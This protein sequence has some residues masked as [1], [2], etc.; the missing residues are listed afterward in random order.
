MSRRTAGGLLLHLADWLLRRTN[1][2]NS[3]WRRP[4]IA[5]SPQHVPYPFHGLATSAAGRLHD[6][7]HLIPAI[8]FRNI[9]RAFLRVSSMDMRDMKRIKRIRNNEN[10]RPFNTGDDPSTNLCSGQCDHSTCAYC[11]PLRLTPFDCGVDRS[12]W[13]PRAQT[14]LSPAPVISSSIEPE[15]KAPDPYLVMPD[16]QWYHHHPFPT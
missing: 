16:H 10:S 13:I 4:S 8:C 11:F 15:T 2:S 9:L 6:A 1:P 3:L 14:C 5:V 12:G 7:V